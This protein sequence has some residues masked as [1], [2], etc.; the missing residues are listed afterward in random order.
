MERGTVQAC[1]AA[2]ANRGMEL[3]R[4]TLEQEQECGG[5]ALVEGGENGGGKEGPPDGG[6][7]CLLPTEAAW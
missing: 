3:S 6:T 4:P 7:P 2:A 1:R 5:D